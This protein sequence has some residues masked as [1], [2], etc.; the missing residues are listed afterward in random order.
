MLGGERIIMDNP[1]CES[2]CLYFSHLSVGLPV[3]DG[4]CQGLDQK[5]HISVAVMVEEFWDYWEEEGGCQLN[6]KELCNCVVVDR[7]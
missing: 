6:T 5:G 2:V 7:Y 1:G 3:N 4:A